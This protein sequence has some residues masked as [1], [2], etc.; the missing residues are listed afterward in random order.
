[1][2]HCW[3]KVTEARENH[4]PLHGAVL[5][6][7]RWWDSTGEGWHEPLICISSSRPVWQRESIH[8]PAGEWPTHTADLWLEMPHVAAA[9]PEPQPQHRWSSTVWAC[10]EWAGLLHCH[11]QVLQPQLNQQH[12]NAQCLS[13]A[14]S[15][16]PFPGQGL[17]GDKTKARNSKTET[18]KQKQLFYK[19]FTFPGSQDV[20]HIQLRWTL[21]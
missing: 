12:R 11:S 21:L 10:P 3:V 15:T 4:L 8:H 13:P 9:A 18:A 6:I 19:A 16:A 14:L 2:Q 7:R 1:M 20:N 5:F 17:R